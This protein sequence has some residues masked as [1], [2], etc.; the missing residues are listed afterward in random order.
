MDSLAWKVKNL[1]KQM[2]PLVILGFVVYYGYHMYRRGVF[3]HGVGPAVTYVLRQVPILGSHFRHRGYH[4]SYRHGYRHG[5]R[6]GRHHRRHHRR[7]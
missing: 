3:R 6:H 1:F 7:R 4:Y 5:H 2:L